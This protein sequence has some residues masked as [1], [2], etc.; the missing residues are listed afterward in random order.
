[1][2]PITAPD[3]IQPLCRARAIYA[4][5][6]KE[7]T[8]LIFE[9]GALIDVLSKVESG[10]WLG[11]TASSAPGWFPKDYVQVIEPQ[12]PMVRLI[13]LLHLAHIRLHL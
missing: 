13:C 2:A 3:A 7:P 1:M 6:S 9:P 8:A 10:W 5:Q 12:K 11:S 4:F